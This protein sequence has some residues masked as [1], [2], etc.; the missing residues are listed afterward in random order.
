M[1]QC[2]G[3]DWSQSNNENVEYELLNNLVYYFTEDYTGGYMTMA[4]DEN[5]IFS[6]MT[7]S[8]TKQ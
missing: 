7:Y 1:H 8:N 6:E 2:L 4:F 3:K 5:G